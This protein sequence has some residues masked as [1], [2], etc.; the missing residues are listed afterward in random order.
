[1][2]KV[3][4]L[5]LGLAIFSTVYI[6]EAKYLATAELEEIPLPGPGA[7]VPDWPCETN[8]TYG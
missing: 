4:I 8:A 1:M 7:P 2:N 6:E 3:F 5:T